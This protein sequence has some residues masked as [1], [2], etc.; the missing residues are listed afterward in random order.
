MFH[1][2]II[3]LQLIFQHSIKRTLANQYLKRISHLEWFRSI[4]N[5][6]TSISCQGIKADQ[7]NN[8]FLGKTP[9]MS[10]MTK[11]ITHTNLHFSGDC[12]FDR[13]LFVCTCLLCVYVCFACNGNKFCSVDFI[14]TRSHRC[15]N[16]F[17]PKECTR[18]ILYKLPIY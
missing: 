15:K 17:A 9:L 1:R 4:G 6:I 5:Q 16:C 14:L 2:L 3:L 10:S 13:C 18:K 11:S 8:F 12:I 7:F